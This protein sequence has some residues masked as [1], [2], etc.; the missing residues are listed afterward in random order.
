[1]PTPGADPSQ[2][3]PAFKALLERLST[4]TQALERASEGLA[5]P[6]ELSDAAAQAKESLSNA[7]KVGSDL[8]EAVRAMKLKE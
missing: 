6:A 4:E 1:V 3:G 2:G 5:S 7:M 8:L